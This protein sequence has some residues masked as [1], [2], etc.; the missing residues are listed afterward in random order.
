MKKIGIF[1][2]FVFVGII[3]IAQNRIDVFKNEKILDLVIYIDLSKLLSDRDDNRVYHNAELTVIS[4]NEKEKNIPVKVR[5]RGNFRRKVENCTFPSLHIKFDSAARSSTIFQKYKKLKL[6]TH[7]IDS[8]YIIEEYLLYKMYNLF[9]D[10]SYK[11][12]LVHINYIDL[13]GDYDTFDAFGFLIEPTQN[14]AIRTNSKKYNNK[15]YSLDSVE[16]K[17]K[18]AV[19]LFEF[20]IG[21]TD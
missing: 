12:R 21:N 4:N 3:S 19:Y 6:A 17:H 1:C 15:I 16:D 11:V 8:T 2:Y 14:L 13:S 18:V 10:Y 20:M 9:T 5:V 7:C